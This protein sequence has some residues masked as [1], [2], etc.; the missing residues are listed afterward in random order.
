[1]IEDSLEPLDRLSVSLPRG[2][3]PTGC[4][5][6]DP[7]THKRHLVS[8]FHYPVFR[9]HLA[10]APEGRSLFLRGRGRRGVG[11]V[12]PLSFLVKFYLTRFFIS[13]AG[14]TRRS[15]VIHLHSGHW[16][17]HEDCGAAGRL[18]GA[19]WMAPEALSSKFFRRPVGS[20]REAGSTSNLVPR[21]V[22]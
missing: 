3:D 5:F 9:E 8:L 17:G 10:R 16:S 1:M 20:Q 11:E 7:R 13:V 22:P 18:S 19:S 2:C 6:K 21:Q 12:I 4:G 14:F 15:P